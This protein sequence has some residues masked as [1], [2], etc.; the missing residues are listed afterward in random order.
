MSSELVMARPNQPVIHNELHDLES[1]FNVL[2]DI[3]IQY[4]E[5]SKLK[6]DRELQNCFDK[7]FNTTE[8]SI[9][10]SNY[11]YLVF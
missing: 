2:I 6:P 1:F 4:D 3:S 7:L 8:L 9:L 11:I 10:K 5:P